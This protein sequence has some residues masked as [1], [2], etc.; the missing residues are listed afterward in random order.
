MS[1]SDKPAKKT[2]KNLEE[3]SKEELI[4][5]F[6]SQLEQK[7]QFKAQLSDIQE[8]SAN[9]VLS[10]PFSNLIGPPSQIRGRVHSDEADAS[11]G[12]PLAGER[13]PG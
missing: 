9:L 7:E 10:L 1:S 2:P 11:P 3:L 4:K 8:T 5:L 13:E 12:R 6:H